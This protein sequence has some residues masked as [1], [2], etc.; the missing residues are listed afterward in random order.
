MRIVGEAEGRRHAVFIRDHLGTRL[1]HADAPDI[2]GN[3]QT[4]KQRQVQGQ[5]RFADVE[6][7]KPVLLQKDDM[8]AFL[9][10]QRRDG[11]T[12]RPTADNEDIAFLSGL[13]RFAFLLRLRDSAGSLTPSAWRSCSTSKVRAPT[14]GGMGESQG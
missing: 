6:T 11:G 7:W 1:V 3:T 5:Q 12:G 8:P 13:H 14:S 4:F 10:K 9:G 2:L